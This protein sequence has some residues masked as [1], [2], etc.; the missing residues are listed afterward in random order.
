MRQRIRLICMICATMMSISLSATD[1][2]EFALTSAPSSITD[3][4]Y[5]GLVVNH[6]D[7]GGWSSSGANMNNNKDYIEFDLSALDGIYI[8][9]ATVYVSQGGMLVVIRKHTFFTRM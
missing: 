6:Y 2:I 7:V 9:N 1:P 4:T 3:G 8:D 5:D